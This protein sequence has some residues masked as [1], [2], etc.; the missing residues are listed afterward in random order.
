MQT[1]MFKG[2]GTRVRFL[3]RF[4][5]YTGL[6]LA[7]LLVLSGAI[8]LWAC[9]AD[10]QNDGN[11]VNTQNLVPL[12]SPGNDSQVI[13]SATNET[14][15]SAIFTPSDGSQI[16]SQANIYP[17]RVRALKKSIL[18]F[19]VFGPLLEIN[20]V[21]GQ[22][23]KKG[24]VLMRIDPR[25]YQV[26]VDLAQ[27]RLDAA[28]A[29]LDAMRKGARPE[30]VALLQAQVEEATASY[31]LA[32]KEFQ[33]AQ[34][35]VESKT[36]SASEFD[37]AHRTYTLAGLALNSAKKELEK[38]VA[39]ARSE[40]ISAAE[41]QIRGLEA[42][43]AAAKN[44]LDDTTLR[45]PYDG[46]ITTKLIDEHEMVTTTPTYREVLGIHDISRL[47]IEVFVPEREMVAGRIAPGEAVSVRFTAKRENVYEAHLAEID[48]EPSQVGMT[49][50]LTFILD[51]PDDLA[52]LPGM[53][54]EVSF[55]EP[56]E[57]E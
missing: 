54:S 30:D 9:F 46:V 45:A 17:G 21:P 23:V 29:N 12:F 26:Q 50:K 53:V 10:T 24:D 57:K 27:S 1:M 4:P 39:G 38:G 3:R 36:I 28:Q 44:S 16:A 43:L 42:T 2:D 22:V 49:Y 25:D 11:A 34:T 18:T 52:I 31:T 48:T 51:R 37:A 15:E 13:N 8:S 7:A 47:K 32:E 55:P 40:D 6:T 41:A 33:R 5:L 20:V 35:L 19:R 14:S 56:T